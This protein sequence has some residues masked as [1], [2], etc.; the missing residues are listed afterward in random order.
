MVDIELMVHIQRHTIQYN[1]FNE[2]FQKSN[3]T[4]L[5]CTKYYEMNISHSNAQKDNK[6]VST[7]ILKNFGPKRKGFDQI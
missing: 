7:K 4:I 3:L 1:K 5:Y 6:K 2:S